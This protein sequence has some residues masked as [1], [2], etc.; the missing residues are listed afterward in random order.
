M[1]GACVFV[2]SRLRFI[3]RSRVLRFGGASADGDAAA[4]EERVPHRAFVGFSCGPKRLFR[5]LTSKAE[6]VSS[7]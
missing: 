4:A 7:G 5:L 6:V 2:L 1:F 3:R